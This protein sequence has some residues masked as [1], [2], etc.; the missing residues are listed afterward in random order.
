[1]LAL[2]IRNVMIDNPYTENNEKPG[3]AIYLNKLKGPEDQ[4]VSITINNSIDVGSGE[5]YRIGRL[6][7][8]GKRVDGLIRFNHA[9]SRE[10]GAMAITVRNYDAKGPRIE[11]RQ[12]VVVRPNTVGHKSRKY[13]S[14]IVVYRE[15]RDSGAAVL[16]NVHLYDPDIRDDRTVPKIV[17]YIYVRDLTGATIENVT[18][19]GTINGTGI[20][21]ARPMIEFAASGSVADGGSLLR[22]DTGNQNFTLGASNYKRVITNAGSSR[23]VTVTLQDVPENWPIVTIEVKARN[24]LRIKPAPSSYITMDGA[25]PIHQIK[26]HVVGS[27]ISLRR[28]SDRHWCVESKSGQWTARE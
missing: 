25:G 11:F 24:D 13:G 15:P 12:P 1:M 19:N 21:R 27:M 28:C 6:D 23:T 20:S 8:K 9:V 7:L 4:T 14:A 18:V 22:H 26:S 5:S 2:Q 10:S 16:G 3:I 17:R